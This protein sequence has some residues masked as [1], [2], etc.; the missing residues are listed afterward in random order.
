M[1]MLRRPLGKGSVAMTAAALSLAIVALLS[2]F[3]ANNTQA[4]PPAPAQ[5]AEEPAP[6]EGQTYTGS[7]RCSSC[8][9]EAFMS[10]KKTNHA[11]AFDNMPAKYKKGA[12]TS[13]LTCH[14]TAYGHPAGYKGASTPDLLGVTCE[15][16]HGPGS[17]HEEVAKAFADAKKLSPE[18]EKAA[19]DSIWKV[20]PGNVCSRCHISQGHK[21]HPAYDKQ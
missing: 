6:P 19:R 3:F 11:K 5:V 13:C 20:M 12:D 16:C 10:W 21:A 4:Q 8:H 17:K 18:Q 15:A 2:L 9:F 1:R 14:I 7:K